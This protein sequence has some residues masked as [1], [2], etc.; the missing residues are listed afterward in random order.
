M[1]IRRAKQRPERY[2]KLDH[3]IARDD[4]LTWEARGVL[5]YLLT[6]PDNWEANAQDLCNQVSGTRK[7]IGKTTMYNIFNE[8]EEVGY[9][10]RFQPRIRGRMG[11]AITIVGESHD[12]I[13]DAIEEYEKEAANDDSTGSVLT[14]TVVTDTVQPDTGERSLR[15]NN[16]SKNNL[17]K[18]LT[19][20]ERASDPPTHEW[21]YDKDE[22]VSEA[23]TTFLRVY[24]KNP[25]SK[26]MFRQSWWR[27]GCEDI[28]NEIIT[29]L[30]TQLRTCAEYDDPVYCPTAD[31]YIADRKW[32][33]KI[34]PR[35]KPTQNTG[36]IA[37]DMTGFTSGDE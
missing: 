11:K 14:D 18:E 13:S 24:P 30:D 1:T 5:I 4:R 23:M 28:A 17:S 2:Y 29:A 31:N 7:P 15:T 34:V 26:R 16:T 32:E 22:F 20:E 27:L 12:V 36:P 6:K 3:D 21:Q 35:K 37:A 33:N 25:K 8:L 9:M 10:V 19:R